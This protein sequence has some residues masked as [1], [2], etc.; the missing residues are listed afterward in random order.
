M[1][2]MYFSFSVIYRPPIQD[3]HPPPGLNNPKARGSDACRGSNRLW[4]RTL[5]KQ[6]RAGF[7]GCVVSTTSGPP[8]ETT[9]D[10]TQTN[11]ARLFPG[12]KLKFLTPPGWKGWTL[13]TSLGDGLL[14][15]LSDINRSCLGSEFIENLFI[16][17]N[18]ICWIVVELKEKNCV[19]DRDLNPG[20]QL[21]VLVRLPLRFPV[22]VPIHDRINIFEPSF[23][24]SGPT[25][26]VVITS[27]RGM[28]SYT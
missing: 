5:D 24:T 22:L 23:L 8:S 4:T 10:R 12:Q 25:N 17:A 1:H 7:L 3:L 21:Y 20:L 28:H 14:R 16:K 11:N 18:A 27:Y 2:V 15:F 9:Q 26:S 13:P 6:T 19:L